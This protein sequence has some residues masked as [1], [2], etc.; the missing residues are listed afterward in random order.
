[1]NTTQ[2]RAIN[3]AAEVIA[4]NAAKRYAAG[5]S[6]DTAVKGAVAEFAERWPKL[7]AAVAGRMA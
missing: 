2:E 5:A 3:R 4:N 6:M 7:A 1:M